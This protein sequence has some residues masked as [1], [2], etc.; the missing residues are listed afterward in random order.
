MDVDLQ[1]ICESSS[2]S[3]DGPEAAEEDEE[4]GEEGETA[5]P[6]EEDG[7]RPG[8]AQV[9]GPR[10]RT[11]QPVCVCVCLQENQERAK[12][13]RDQQRERELQFRKQQRERAEQGAR[14][15][16]L[17]KCKNLCP[18]SPGPFRT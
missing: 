12:K 18:L 17:K 4:P 1:D 5:V 3:A 8:W 7:R 15:F 14:P 16:F 11:A 2:L 10:G 13:S 6:S 9:P